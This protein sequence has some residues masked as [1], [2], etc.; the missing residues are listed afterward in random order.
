MRVRAD[1]LT[2]VRE[3]KTEEAV[4]QLERWDLLTRKVQVGVFLRTGR[5]APETARVT[6]DLRERLEELRDAMLAG[7]VDKGRGLLPVVEAAYRKCRAQYPT[8]PDR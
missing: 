5:L 2:A 3:G 6:D 1:A 8:A 4:R 7:E